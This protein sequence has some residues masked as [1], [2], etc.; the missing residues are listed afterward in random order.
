MTFES[1][2]FN[3]SDVVRNHYGPRKII[4]FSGEVSTSDK[5]KQISF[6]VDV[7]DIITDGVP[8]TSNPLLD[9][10]IGKMEAFIPA[11][12]IIK[13]C[14]VEVIEALSTTTGSGVTASQILVGLD[15]VSD[16]T[17]I[18]A[19]GLIDATDG[20]LTI[21]STNVLEPAGSVLI[22]ANAALV[23]N[24]S[25]GADDAQLYV[26]WAIDVITAIDAVAGKLNV[27]VTY[28]DSKQDGAG[29][30]GA[31]GVKGNG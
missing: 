7:A 2:A 30:Y 18:D 16:G 29:T 14:V 4:D 31:G 10:A 1:G 28:V 5:E 21:A 20:A 15:K 17:A 19:D 3:S 22:G 12:A 9:P 23:P 25:V 26:A 6:T 13:S 11:N 8:A 24:F 27:L